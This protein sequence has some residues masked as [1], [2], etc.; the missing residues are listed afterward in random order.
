MTRT[1]VTDL[2]SKAKAATPGPWSRRG[3]DVISNKIT[4]SNNRNNA[5]CFIEKESSPQMEVTSN[6]NYIASA[7]PEAIT[8]LAE[9]YLEALE[10]IRIYDSAFYNDRA[11]VSG[12]F[13][14]EFLRK[15][16]ET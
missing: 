11:Y 9:S 5:V 2:L 15:I 1:E 7:N 6:A 12:N 8:R 10:V 13:A 16:G 14:H 4:Y 3:S